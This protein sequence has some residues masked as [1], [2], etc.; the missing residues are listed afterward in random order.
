MNDDQMESSLVEK[1]VNGI[2]E[3]I[4]SGR[5]VQG[6]RLVAADLA[7]QFNVSRAP[8]R[9]ALQ[10]LAG[11]GVV[12]LLPNRGARIRRLSLDDL[13][14]FLEFSEAIL[15]LGIRLAA[16]R[17]KN[18]DKRTVLTEAFA[19]IERTWESRDAHA[20]VRALYQYH[21]Q[22]HALAG[23]DFLNLF[24]CRPEI[25]FY[26]L[27]LASIVPGDSWDRYLENYRQI[28]ETLLEG[29]P[30]TAVVT[31]SAHMRWVVRLMRAR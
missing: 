13:V 14:E 25:R 27:L 2:L 7:Q 12:E 26:S 18:S 22:L 24:Y 21:V 17:L 31:F 5:F 29:D 3:G 30:H 28:H 23:N 9:E 11:D 20:F 15:V 1:A 8:I 6:Q 16:P 4:M 19:D 10:K